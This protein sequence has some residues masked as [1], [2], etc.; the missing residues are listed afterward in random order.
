MI[1]CSAKLEKEASNLNHN[2]CIPEIQKINREGKELLDL[3][4]NVL[5][6]KMKG[7]KVQVQQ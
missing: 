4:N 3:I 2:V 7:D 1:G 6:P 5:E